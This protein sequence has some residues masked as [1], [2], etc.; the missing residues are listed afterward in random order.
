MGDAR[1]RQEEESNGE[2]GHKTKALPPAAK[3][4]AKPGKK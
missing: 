3:T 4:E 2:K 1:H